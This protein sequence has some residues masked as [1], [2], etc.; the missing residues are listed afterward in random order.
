MKKETAVGVGTEGEKDEGGYGS[1]RGGSSGGAGARRRCRIGGTRGGNLAAPAPHELPPS[2]PSTPRTLPH[3]PPPSF[4]P[5][6][7]PAPPPSALFLHHP[8]IQASPP[9]QAPDHR[10]PSD[11]TPTRTRTTNTRLQPPRTLTD[12]LAGPSTSLSLTWALFALHWL[13]SCASRERMRPR[14]GRRG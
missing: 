11:G 2:C 7:F 10:L 4:P 1:Y 14:S 13:R 12:P 5:Q 6:A 9:P 8:P 3:P